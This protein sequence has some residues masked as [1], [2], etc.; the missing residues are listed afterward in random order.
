M[1][2]G[3]ITS[4]GIQQGVAGW[5]MLNRQLLMVD[6]VQVVAGRGSSDKG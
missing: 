5:R 3:G 1:E 2:G 4:A 6:G